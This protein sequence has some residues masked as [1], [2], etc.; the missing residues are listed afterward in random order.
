MND[1]HIFVGLAVAALVS[2]LAL[3]PVM[4]SAVSTIIG[5]GVSTA[6]HKLNGNIATASQVATDGSDGAFGYAVVTLDGLGGTGDSLMVATTHATV[7]DSETQS[8]TSTLH[9]GTA[10]ECPPVWHTH[11]VQLT[12]AG[13]YCD[14]TNGDLG[15]LEVANLSYETPGEL[16]VFNKNV[17]FKNMPPSFDGTNAVT[18]D[19]MTWTPNT[20]ATLVASF[21]L[22]PVFDGDTL[23]HVCVENV[24]PFAVET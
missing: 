15:R 13:A 23:T 17:H 1:N 4:A 19:P 16:K 20:Q 10:E 22:D 3:A 7:C 9:T 6:P 11:Y 12:S 5:A 2:S 24:S 21:I 8:E 14:D 18:G